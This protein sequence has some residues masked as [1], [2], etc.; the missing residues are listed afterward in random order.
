M[1]IFV[2]PAPAGREICPF[3]SLCT[4]RR[5]RVAAQSDYIEKSGKQPHI[6]I[7]DRTRV[8]EIA[9]SLSCVT[10]ITIITATN[11]QPLRHIPHSLLY[12]FSFLSQ[13]PKILPI[14]SNISH[15]FL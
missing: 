9:V 13:L 8:V 1:E 11:K 7:G 10:A 14:S 12:E 4:L 2:L 3:S 15:H 5:P 6:H